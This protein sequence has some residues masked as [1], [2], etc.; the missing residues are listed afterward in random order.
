MARRRIMSEKW[1]KTL[2][3]GGTSQRGGPRSAVLHVLCSVSIRDVKNRGEKVARMHAFRIRQSA[4]L[5]VQNLTFVAFK[6]NHIFVP[7]QG[8][9]ARI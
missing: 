8:S 3:D 5:L 7:D 9:K 2:T 4:R 6:A 1:R